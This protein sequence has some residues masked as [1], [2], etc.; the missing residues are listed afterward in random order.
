MVELAEKQ[1]ELEGVVFGLDAPLHV[2]AS[3]W[4]P[5]TAALSNQD[6][7]LPGRDSV[8]MGKDFFAGATWQFSM[9]TIAETEEQAWEDVSDLQAVWPTDAL[10]LDSGAVVPL[11]YR[12]AD[13]VR[14]VYG[15]P[16]R[17]TTSVNN[18]SLG[19]LLTIEADFGTVD[20]RVY[21]DVEQSV[22]VELAPPVDTGQGVIPPFIPPYVPSRSDQTR[23][24]TVQ[25]GGKVPTPVTITIDGDVDA[26]VV[27]LASYVDP[28]DIDAGTVE[29]FKAALRDPVVA[30]NPVTFDAR[31]WARSVTKRFGGGAAVNPRISRVSEMYLPPG[32]HEITFTGANPTGDATATVAWRNARRTPR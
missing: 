3:G 30:G 27:T 28:D 19:G 18:G 10:R 22:T 14:R 6:V 17:F 11:R 31:P 4:A 16:R 7:Q 32:Q 24:T 12:V 21:D 20:H 5:G 8:R 9:F 29:L 15:R 13:V 1:W 26:A 23:K 2:E 25:V